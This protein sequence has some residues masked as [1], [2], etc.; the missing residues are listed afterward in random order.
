MCADLR[1]GHGTS[2]EPGLVFLRGSFLEP[3]S[4]IVLRVF[5]PTIII[6]GYL[7]VLRGYF[8]AHRTMTQTSISQIL[9][10]IA[11]AFVSVFGALF[12]TNLVKDSDATTR[13]IYGA[14]GSAAGTGAGVI[15]AL[16][17]M[18]WTYW[19]NRKTIQKRA[20]RDLSG[21]DQSYEMI[22]KSLILIVTPIIV[23][24]CIYNMNVVV[25]QTVFIRILM[26]LKEFTEAD[27]SKLYGVFSGRAVV[28]ANIPIALGAAMS[29]AMIPT[30]ST[31]YAKGEIDSLNQKI[32]GGIKVTMMLSVPAA[33]GLAVLARPVT[34]LLSPEAEY[35]DMAIMLL[36]GLS[37][38]VLF[39]QLSTISN[40]VLQGIGK[41]RV[42]VINS[43]IALIAQTVLIIPLLIYT[44]LLQDCLVIATI[45]YS[46]T[47][48]MLNQWS[49][50]KYLNYKQEMLNTF[51]APFA[52]SAVMGV[53]AYLVYEGLLMIHCHYAIALLVAIVIAV[54]VY[55]V[56]IILIGGMKE[57]DMRKIPKGYLLVKAAK[58][59]HLLK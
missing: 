16:L 44:D 2:G 7:G 57:E 13:A 26:R 20:E 52:A 12:L 36:R 10:Q 14:C 9:E 6:Y 47:I 50:H 59:V 29:S 43:A 42:P 30:I 15:V 18:L 1:D 45:F 49:V 22:F 3:N 34:Y 28:I 11:N 55:F 48:C 51:V 5:T 32:S 53:I 41:V 23:S 21:A 58:K 4:A 25:N 37:V 27:A 46:F 19:M 31:S 8:Q 39:Y 24:S 33:V 56:T 40:G 17:F 54:P 35:M 38:T